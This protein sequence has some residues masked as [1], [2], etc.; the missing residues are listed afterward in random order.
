MEKFRDTFIYSQ[1]EELHE[2]KNKMKQLQ[3]ELEEA[4]TKQVGQ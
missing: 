4:K 1:E 2:M 3:A